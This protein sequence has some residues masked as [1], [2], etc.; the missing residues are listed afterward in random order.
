MKFDG[1]QSGSAASRLEFRVFGDD[2][3]SLW[4][5]LTTTFAVS[6]EDERTDV[7]FLGGDPTHV[8]KLRGQR[9]LDLKVLVGHAG[10]YEKWRPRGQ[11][12][13][14]A[15]GDIL[16]VAFSDTPD[17]PEV[18]DG[19]Q[20]DPEQLAVIFE[21]E[22]FLPVSVFK[23]RTMF[24]ARS[25]TVEFARITPEGRDTFFTIALESEDRAILDQLRHRLRLSGRRN[26]SYP[27]MLAGA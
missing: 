18:V 16:R 2:L 3:E 21:R 10:D 26:L 25:A 1:N 15:E 17:L 12:D 4:E 9:T 11:C 27:K 8:F 22:G 20:Y 19:K 24:D 7:Y 5:E 14:P 13:L 23:R 6:E